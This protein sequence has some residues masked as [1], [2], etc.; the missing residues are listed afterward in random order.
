MITKASGLALLFLLLAP[1]CAPTVT[2]AAPG[3]GAR[4]TN[5]TDAPWLAGWEERELLRSSIGY[6]PSGSRARGIGS[7]PSTAFTR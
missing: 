5:A 4:T 7:G 1:G 2:A 3:V 6:G